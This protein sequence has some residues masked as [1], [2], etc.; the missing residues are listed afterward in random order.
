[1]VT[2]KISIQAGL[3]KYNVRFLSKGQIKTRDDRF[4]KIF[5]EELFGKCP[6]IFSA[7]NLKGEKTQNMSSHFNIQ[8]RNFKGK[9]FKEILGHFFPI[10]NT[11]IKVFEKSF[12]E[13]NLKGKTSLKN[14]R[15]RFQRSIKENSFEKIANLDSKHKDERFWKI[16][17]SWTFRKMPRYFFR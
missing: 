7:R 14:V 5:W 6:A 8:E 3:P 12:E 9:S 17:L 13:R 10:Q 16:F 4:W 11:K 1:M 15:L 2:K